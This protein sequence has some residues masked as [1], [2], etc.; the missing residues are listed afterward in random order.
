[1]A[2]RHAM[3]AVV[4]TAA[5]LFAGAGWAQTA[6]APRGARPEGM[7]PMHGFERLHKALNLDG[8]QEELWNQART[9]QRDMF[10]TMRAQAAETRAKLRV[11]IDK[12]G[13]DLKQFAQYADQVRAQMR[14]QMETLHKQV[15]AAWFK[16]YDSLDPKQK[17]Q[18]RVAVRDGMDRMGA[19]RGRHR[20]GHE[21]MQS[22]RFGE[23]PGDPGQG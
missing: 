12:P 23:L 10:E 5:A 21:E 20:G 13:V 9:A 3:K 14:A 17:E 11:E 8:Q 19:H 7:G 16:L 2:L 15:Q 6:D 22:E 4:L 18:A 1:M